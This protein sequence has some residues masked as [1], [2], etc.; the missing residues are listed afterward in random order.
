MAGNCYTKK[1]KESAGCQLWFHGQ[2]PWF[3][4]MTAPLCPVGGTCFLCDDN[5]SY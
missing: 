4:S 2:V 1:D 5:V 3:G